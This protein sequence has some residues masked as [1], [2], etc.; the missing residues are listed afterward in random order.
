VP[1]ETAPVALGQDP[2]PYV[3]SAYQLGQQGVDWRQ[4]W[5]RGIRTEDATYVVS[6]GQDMSKTRI[7]LYDNRKDKYQLNPRELKEHAS[8]YKS[9]LQHWLDKSGDEFRLS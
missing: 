4:N 1:N 7:L 8:E 2:S 3:V 9:V 5:Y 6:K